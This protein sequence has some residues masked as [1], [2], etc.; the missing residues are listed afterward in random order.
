M[1]WEEKDPRNWHAQ[2][3]EV[4]GG[5]RIPG[6]ASGPLQLGAQIPRRADCLLI[7]EVAFAPLDSPPAG[8]CSISALQNQPFLWTSLETI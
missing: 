4:G 5:G 8:N 7:P 1:R 2:G 3:W 6:E